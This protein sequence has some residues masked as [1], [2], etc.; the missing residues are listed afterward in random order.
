MVKEREMVKEKQR[1]RKGEEDGG[2]P[3]GKP[4]QQALGDVCS[5]HRSDGS[6]GVPLLDQCGPH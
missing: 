1:E 2:R 6:T 4:G 5:V 3:H